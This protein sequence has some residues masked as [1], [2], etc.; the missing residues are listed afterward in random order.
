VKV[1]GEQPAAGCLSRP[2]GAG[3]AVR[4]RTGVGVGLVGVLARPG[5]E[6][7]V[8]HGTDQLQ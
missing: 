7:K 6:I 8:P 5:A 3:A 1:E 2:S 4:A